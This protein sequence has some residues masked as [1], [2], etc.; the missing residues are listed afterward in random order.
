MLPGAAHDYQYAPKH[1][2]RTHV[3]AVC[4]RT[5]P[6]H[7]MGRSRKFRTLL[8]QQVGSAIYHHLQQTNEDVGAVRLFADRGKTG[9]KLLNGNQIGKANGYENRR[10]EDEAKRRRKWIALSW[11]EQ[12]H[13]EIKLVV[14]LNETAGRFD[15][16]QLVARGHAHAKGM[17]HFLGFGAGRTKEVNPNR[18][19]VGSMRCQH[20]YPR[21]SIP[22]STV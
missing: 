20:R 21:V 15:F 10:G 6:K 7:Q 1:P 4:S 5:L 2:G 14:A 18:A 3:L 12:G 17:L 9:R 22:R 16:A 13:A 8:L 19:P 11:R